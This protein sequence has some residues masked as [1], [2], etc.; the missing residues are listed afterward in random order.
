[1]VIYC[2]NFE[3][4]QKLDH[5]VHWTTSVRHSAGCALT[6]ATHKSSI[7][8][9]SKIRALFKVK[10]YLDI[11]HDEPSLHC[12]GYCV[13]GAHSQ[14][15]DAPLMAEHITDTVHPLPRILRHR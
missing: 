9:L 3:Y 14:N 1:M 7:P 6:L 15:S 8:N 4:F 12:G 10:R 2:K 5:L 11:T 13:A